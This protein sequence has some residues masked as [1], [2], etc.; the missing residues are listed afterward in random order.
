MAAGANV[1][2]SYARAPGKLTE[3]QAEYGGERLLVVQSDLGNAGAG[4][5][6]AG[7]LGRDLA[8][9]SDQGLSLLQ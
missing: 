7:R 9:E 1:V 8:E 5:E 3:L 2:G 6:D 4:D